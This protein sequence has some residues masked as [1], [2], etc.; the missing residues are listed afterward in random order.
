MHARGSRIVF[1]N[2]ASNADNNSKKLKLENIMRDKLAEFR[3]NQSQEKA[4]KHKSSPKSEFV[5][6]EQTISYWQNTSWK[7][8]QYNRQAWTTNR[9]EK[10]KQRYSH[11]KNDVTQD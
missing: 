11:S 7:I 9:K 1:E 3:T 8:P 2:P 10:D 5:L 4:A 6:S